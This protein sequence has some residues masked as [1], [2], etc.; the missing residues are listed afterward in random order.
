MQT[1]NLKS[2][3]TQAVKHNA[4]VQEVRVLMKEFKLCRTQTFSRT[5][6]LEGA[7]Q[8]VAEHVF[9]GK[10]SHGLDSVNDD[11]LQLIHLGLG[12]N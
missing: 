1:S 8:F 12:S 7:H 2:L 4:Q 5:C 11:Y 10:H 9:L 6:C 3:F